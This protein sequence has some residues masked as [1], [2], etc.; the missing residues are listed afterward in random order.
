MGLPAFC[1]LAAAAGAWFAGV[2][3]ADLTFNKE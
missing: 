2:A 1:A 3:W